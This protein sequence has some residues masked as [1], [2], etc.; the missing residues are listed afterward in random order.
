M[1]LL[2]I[3]CLSSL[4][5]CLLRLCTPELV[6][7]LDVA[8]LW[9][10]LLYVHQLLGTLVVGGRNMGLSRWN[11]GASFRIL[12]KT[13]KWDSVRWISPL[14]IPYETG[15]RTSHIV[16]PGRQFFRILSMAHPLWDHHKCLTGLAKQPI[17]WFLGIS[18]EVLRKRRRL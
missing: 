1:V 9:I 8:R 5:D 12:D 16:C 4:G 7:L 13:T 11:Q 17:W 3:C 18:N 15:D 2:T 6:L 10:F 14:D